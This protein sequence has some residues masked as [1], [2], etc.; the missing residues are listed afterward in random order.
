M[1]W[2]SLS[3]KLIS[4]PWWRHQPPTGS[5]LW[6]QAQIGNHKTKTKA[7]TSS[8]VLHPH[9]GGLLSVEMSSDCTCCSAILDRSKQLWVIQAGWSTQFVFFVHLLFLCGENIH[10]SATLWG[11]R[12]AG[13]KLMLRPVT[14]MAASWTV[15]SLFTLKISHL[16]D[17]SVDKVLGAQAQGPDAQTYVESQMHQWRF[18]ILS[19]GKQRQED[20][21]GSSD[22]NF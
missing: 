1:L 2:R 16:G 4:E 9:R 13:G 14:L 6:A 11:C 3:Q 12:S 7:H 22:R 10:S 5:K 21:S 15:S 18:V 8:C 20:L 17:G 19:L